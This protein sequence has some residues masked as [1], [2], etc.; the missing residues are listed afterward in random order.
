MLPSITVL[1]ATDTVT[2]PGG[3]TMSVVADAVDRATE[4]AAVVGLESV[5]ISVSA[6]SST[7]SAM[8]GIVIVA[9]LVPATSVSVLPVAP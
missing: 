7:S 9:V 3:S 6:F 5:T 2:V 1:S 8:V 4:P